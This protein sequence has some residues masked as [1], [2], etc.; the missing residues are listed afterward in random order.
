MHHHCLGWFY[1]VAKGRC[2]QG[3]LTGLFRCL[4]I[5][6]E[7]PPAN[8]GQKALLRAAAAPGFGRGRLGR[9]SEAEKQDGE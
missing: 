8:T 3:R 5:T 4:L 7:L 9:A 1:C 2:L 6:G